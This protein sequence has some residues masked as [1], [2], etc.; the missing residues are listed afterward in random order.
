M[1]SISQ[2]QMLSINSDIQS[3]ENTLITLNNNLLDFQKVESAE[4]VDYKISELLQKQEMLPYW[5][6]L[7]EVQS[8]F[9]E[10]KLELITNQKPHSPYI[11]KI[12]EKL[13]TV[14]AAHKKC[15][16][17][18]NIK[19]SQSYFQDYCL[20]FMKY[21]QKGYFEEAVALIQQHKLDVNKSWINDIYNWTNPLHIAIELKDG[22]ELMRLLIKEGADVT[23]EKLIKA[24]DYRAHPPLYLTCTGRWSS[25]E[26]AQLLIDHGAP[27]NL[28]IQ[29]N[30]THTPLVE[31]LLCIG[32]YEYASLLIFNGAEIDLS[33]LSVW[34]R[35]F[36][37]NGIPILRQ[38]I[39]IRD[40]VM[41]E[42]NALSPAS[43]NC[44]IKSPM[45]NFLF[46]AISN[47]PLEL[48][49]LMAQ[50]ADTKNAMR[51]EILRRCREKEKLFTSEGV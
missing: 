3:L 46:N 34:N 10:A 49:D 41:K 38:K 45:E 28:K 43:N 7:L 36:V 1:S 15:A 44:R 29:V 24:S 40:Q 21:C 16:D 11:T 32:N 2:D 42:I 23:G 14:F 33:K 8:T 13:N 9:K 20:S 12:I 51:L 6:V 35:S 37:P 48:I 19:R 4:L 31:W 17:I 27:V 30:D 25:L 5:E 47:V 26:K 22:L 39:E 50:Y 18:E